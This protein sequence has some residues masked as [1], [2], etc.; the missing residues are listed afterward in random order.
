MI[1]K[2]GKKLR[3]NEII[4]NGMETRAKDPK[5]AGKTE[6]VISQILTNES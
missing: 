1:A 4:K 6:P 2:R 3:I 5:A